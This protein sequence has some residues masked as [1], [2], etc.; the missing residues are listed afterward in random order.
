MAT[1][2]KTEDVT[3]SEGGSPDDVTRTG[4]GNTD[5]GQGNG[6]VLERT[7]GSPG[8]TMERF[9][10]NVS[11]RFADSQSQR[12]LPS[13][14]VDEESVPVRVN[15]ALFQV[16]SSNPGGRIEVNSETFNDDGSLDKRYPIVEK[17]LGDVNPDGE[18]LDT[19]LFVPD[20]ELIIS[21]GN[22]VR[23]ST[24]D[25]VIEYSELSVERV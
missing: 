18:G 22:V 8:G 25:V 6:V 24:F 16:A 9:T 1:F 14:E 15:Y 12:D 5:L 13:T 2:T 20:G 10:F 3:G 23:V 19:V 21:P 4:G 17:D 11:R 7:L